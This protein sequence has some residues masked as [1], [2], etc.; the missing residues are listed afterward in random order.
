MIL[1][2]KRPFPKSYNIF[3][4][5]FGHLHSLLNN[6]V[7]DPFCCSFNG[8]PMWLLNS[9][10]VHSLCVYWKKLLRMLWRVHPMTHCNIIAHCLINYHY[11]L[12]Q[13]KDLQRLSRNVY[14]VLTL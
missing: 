5:N 8:S 3:V 13:R 10:A 7:F 11:I 12:T 6:N 1:A 14:L 4:S 9:T 2:A